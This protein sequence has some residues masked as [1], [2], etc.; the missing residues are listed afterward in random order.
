MDT[1]L[2]PTL[3]WLDWTLLAVLSLSVI[4][5]LMRGVVFE[6][7]A[8][9]G[10]VAAWFAAQWSAPHVAAR[11]AL[12]AAASALNLAA[13]FTLAFVAALVVWSLAARLIRM[14]VH[15]TPLSVPDRLLGA[16]FGALR[17]GVLLLAVAA[18]VALT[19][20]AQS[21]AW[22]ASQGAR[23]LDGTLQALRPWLP[24]SAARALSA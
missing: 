20:A 5:G 21:M 10:W 2:L 1:T 15:A 16:G 14:V 8:L 6:C 17:G 19:P 12:G 3:S 4:V 24:E 7:L 22:R 18:V 23:W 11:L 13:A 9:A